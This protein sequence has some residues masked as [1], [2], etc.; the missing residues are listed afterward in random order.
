MSEPEISG[1]KMS[2]PGHSLAALNDAGLEALLRRAIRITLILGGLAA[3]ALWKASGWRNAAMMATGT[4]VSAASIV[5]W[6]RLV[7][8]LNARLDRKETPRGAAVA[9]VFFVLRLTVFGAVIYGS[10]KCLRGS[11]TAL[12]CGLGL[13][14]LA[15]AWE[16]IGLLRN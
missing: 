9:A 5:E 2:G 1:P 15:M 16:A 8:L 7:R 12:L 3:L 13:A 4:A 11:V 10:L 6:R 14:V